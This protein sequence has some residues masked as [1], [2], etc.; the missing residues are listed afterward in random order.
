MSARLLR[1]RRPLGGPRGPPHGEAEEGLRAPGG[2]G[3]GE[4]GALD[5]HL[6]ASQQVLPHLVGGSG[7]ASISPAQ[8]RKGSWL[9]SWS[10]GERDVSAPCLRQHAPRPT[11]LSGRGVRHAPGGSARAEHCPAWRFK[12]IKRGVLVSGALS[13]VL[14]LLQVG[15]PGLVVVLLVFVLI[16]CVVFTDKGTKNVCRLMEARRGVSA[17]SQVRGSRKKKP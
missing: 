16:F 11:P 17:S 10:R 2:A 5:P 1:L 8:P 15:W 9:T 12:V 3:A 4:A 14:G 7:F 6:R 13:A